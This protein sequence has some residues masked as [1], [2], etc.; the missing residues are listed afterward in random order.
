[1]ERS[2]I[3]TFHI[4]HLILNANIALVFDAGLHTSLGGC[5]RRRGPY[6]F[7]KERKQGWTLRGPLPKS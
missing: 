7:S 6:S 5:Y 3:I 1:M 2:T 4:V